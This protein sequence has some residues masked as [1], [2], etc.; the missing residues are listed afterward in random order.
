VEID[1]WQQRWQNDQTGF[2]LPEVNECLLRYWPEIT[3]QAAASS[4]VFVPLCGKSLDLIWLASQSA[5]VLGVECSEKAVKAF[6]AEQQLEM[7]V[8]T[9]NDFNACSAANITLYQGDF[10]ALD[11]DMLSSSSLVY[12]RA[13]LVALPEAMRQQYVEKL[14]DT[15][16]EAASIL[17]ITLEYNQQLMS[18]PPFSVTDNE[19]L[20]L[21]KPFFNIERLAERDIIDNEQGFKGKGLDYLFERVYKISR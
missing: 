13:S 20:Q 10:F 15:L 12:D 14:A 4:S 8:G 2:H 3:Q 21:Y 1:F 18:G 6:F 7:K 9:V 17:L 19:V 11:K 5:S 16:P